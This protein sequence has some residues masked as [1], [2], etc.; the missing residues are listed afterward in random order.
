MS[1][2]KGFLTAAASTALLAAAPAPPAPSASPS[3]SPSS[4]P[5]SQ[6]SRAFAERMR[7]FD[8]SLTDKQLETIASGIDDNLKLGDRVN[9]K[10]RV[11][12]NWN[13]PDTIFEAGA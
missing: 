5:P 3:P 1:T 4:P 9:P 7:K 13:E 12:K 8:P 6:L 10:G 2:R 11:L